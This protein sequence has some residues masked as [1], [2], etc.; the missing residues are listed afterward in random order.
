MGCVLYIPL[1]TVAG[2][3]VVCKE[4]IEQKWQQKECNRKLS[5]KNVFIERLLKIQ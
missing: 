2:M 5:N 1:L 3:G 4:Y